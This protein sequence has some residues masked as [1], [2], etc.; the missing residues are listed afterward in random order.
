MRPASIQEFKPLLRETVD[1]CIPR[2]SMDSLRTS[3]RSDA[4]KPTVNLVEIADEAQARNAVGDLIRRRSELL[5][6]EVRRVP[7]GLSYRGT[8]LRN[9]RLLA[10]YPF[11]SLSHG[12]SVSETGGFI[13]RDEVPPWDT[14]VYFAGDYLV[15]WFPGNLESAVQSAIDC[16]AEDSIVWLSDVEDDFVADVRREGLI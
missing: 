10:H 7:T 13:D 3:L 5:Q 15:T 6:N 9:G 12:F 16:N 4:L 11:L 8:Y 1:W 14:W 2:F